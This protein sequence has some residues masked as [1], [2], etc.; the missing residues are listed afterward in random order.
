MT[1]TRIGAGPRMSKA[2]V[3]G[4][5]IYTAGQ[6]ADKTVGQSVAE[7]TQEIVDLLGADCL[8]APIT[9]ADKKRDADAPRRGPPGRSPAGVG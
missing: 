4:N 7:Q 8:R 1:I 3:H 9:L 6:V 2:V 5:T